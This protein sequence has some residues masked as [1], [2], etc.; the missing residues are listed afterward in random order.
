MAVTKSTRNKAQRRGQQ[1]DGDG[2]PSEV[3]GSEP[4]Q[5]PLMD[6]KELAQQLC[7]EALMAGCVTSFVELYELSHREPVCVDALANRMFSIPM[8][9]LPTIQGTLVQAERAR[10]TG[11]FREVYDCHLKLANYFEDEL[12]FATSLHFHDLGLEHCKQSSDKDLEGVAHENFG[13]AHERRGNTDMAIRFHETHLRLAEVSRN[14]PMKR[15]ANKNLIRVYMRRAL[16]CEKAADYPRAKELYDKAMNTARA[17]SDTEA[18]GEAYHK[19]GHITVL[20]G[21]LDKALEYQK[22]FLMVSR[23][24]RNDVNEGKAH[25]SL[26]ELQEEMGQMSDAVQSLVGSLDIAEK[27]GDL[28]AICEACTKLGMLHNKQGDYVKASKYLEQN[29]TTA[30]QIGD[31]KLIE[32]ARILVGVARGNNHWQNG[33]VQMVDRDLDGMLRWKCQGLM[34]EA[35]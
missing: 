24:V 29:Y 6:S 5:N 25:V 13:N 9:Q 1:E 20:L 3:D 12:D 35:K 17:N 7:V 34:S 26:A 15:Q 8:D 27:A 16:E 33:F 14:I 11:E 28:T 30:K 22:R 18:E 31:R 10:R 23:E 2:L 19:L 32:K 21:D 4:W